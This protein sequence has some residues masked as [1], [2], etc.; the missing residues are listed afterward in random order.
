MGETRGSVPAQGW[1]RG[2]GWI[3]HGAA[4]GAQAPTPRCPPKPSVS[5]PMPGCALGPPGA[6]GEE[7]P[8]LCP[9][10][11]GCCIPPL[12]E[13]LDGK[14]V[15]SRGDVQR[16]GDGSTDV[17]KVAQVRLLAAKHRSRSPPRPPPGARGSHAGLQPL[18]GFFPHLL[19]PQGRG[20]AAG[21]LGRASSCRVV[22]SEELTAP[23][24]VPP[25]ICCHLCMMPSQG[26]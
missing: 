5:V 7:G 2:W 12:E 8:Q 15:S 25:V 10:Q 9:I 13:K 3:R 4:G 11:G 21:Q 6:T 14:L 22:P 18:A 23:P 24:L 16:S 17:G 20:E 19:Q 1:G 26:M